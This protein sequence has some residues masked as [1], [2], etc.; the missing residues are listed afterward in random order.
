MFAPCVADFSVRLGRQLC[1]IVLL[2][3][4]AIPYACIENKNSP[5]FT[6][7]GSL[8]IIGPIIIIIIRDW[9]FLRM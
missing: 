4:L 1:L 6:D 8:N 5:L 9:G 2:K 3:L 7:F